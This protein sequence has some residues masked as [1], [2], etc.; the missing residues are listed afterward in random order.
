MQPVAARRGFEPHAP[1]RER[2]LEFAAADCVLLWLRRINHGVFKAP[3]MNA[4]CRL[5]ASMFT[6]AHSR[7]AWPSAA[8]N[9]RRGGAAPLASAT[10]E[11]R[12]KP[13]VATLTWN[14]SIGDRLTAENGRQPIRPIT[15]GKHHPRNPMEWRNRRLDAARPT[16]LPATFVCRQVRHPGLHA[17]ADRSRSARANPQDIGRC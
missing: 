3:A 10:G 2:C 5:C 8:E 11:S 9:R 14:V 16:P 6:P 4:G 17:L 13:R 1:R 15:V 7:V 12:N